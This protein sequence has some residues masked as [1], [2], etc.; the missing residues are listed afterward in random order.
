MSGNSIAYWRNWCTSQNEL[1]ITE[2]GYIFKY[3]IFNENSNDGNIDWICCNSKKKLYG[4]IKYFILPS[5]QLSR[6]IGVK[7]N[8]VC[9]FILD[10][11]ETIE[12]LD[13]AELDN[14]KEHIETYKRW[15]YEIN[16]LESLDAQFNEIRDF[17]SKISLEV[18]YRKLIFVEL[19]LFENISS[20]GRTLIEDYEE[21]GVFEI[22]ELQMNLTRDEIIYL[23][24]NINSNKFMLKKIVNLLI[25]RI[26]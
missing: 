10:Y 13:N 16:K 12:Y 20:V 18:D 9:L 4:F 17:I 6:T 19:D 23:F 15:F 14:Y 25:D 7:E 26:M 2:D 1:P 3:G 8:S 21:D 24:E 5:I 22:L 11:D